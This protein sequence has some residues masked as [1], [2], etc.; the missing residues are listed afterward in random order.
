[1]SESLVE[2]RVSR[3]VWN[4]YVNSAKTKASAA[5]VPVLPFLCRVVREHRKR[6]AGDGYIFAGPTGA[7]L[8][9]AN[10]VRPVIVNSLEGSGVEWHGWHAFR[11]GSATNLYRLGVPERTIQAILR[12]ANVST[13][14]AFLREAG[15]ERQSR[16]NG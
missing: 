8:N 10:P 2:I 1:M 7:P 4:R 11:R 16:R 14:L 5:S 12:H 9:L 13:T 6:N 15:F 3:T